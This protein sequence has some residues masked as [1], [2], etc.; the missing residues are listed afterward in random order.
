MKAEMATC[1]TCGKPYNPSELPLD[2][3]LMNARNDRDKCKACHK[4]DNLKHRPFEGLKAMM[5]AGS[6]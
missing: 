3:A 4:D 1:S 6:G 2:M 5:E